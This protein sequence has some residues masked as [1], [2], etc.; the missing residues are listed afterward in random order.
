[1]T[2][3]RIFEFPILI[4]HRECLGLFIISR[5]DPSFSV[6]SEISRQYRCFNATGTQLTVRLLP[7][8]DDVENTDPMSHFV[9]S[10]NDLIDYALR[11]FADSDMVGLSITNE[12]NVQDK[13]IGLSFRRKDQLTA[14]VIWNV[15]QKVTNSRFNALDKLVVNVHAVKMPVGFG[16]D[17]IKIRGRPLEIMAH[18][19]K[20]IVQVKAETNC[21]AHALL[22]A[23]ARV[24][25]DPNYNSYLKGRKIL[26]EVQYLVK[27]P[28][29]NLDNGGG[30]P[31]LIK[32]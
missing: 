25:N 22:I 30:I 20:S 16:G 26:P 18:L 23:K 21:L 4:E 29:I 1:M 8:P 27:E 24:D 10:M 12:E 6:D 28:G 32:F 31:E 2:F 11:D 17:C 9:A 14:D 5:M 7:P 15:F 3:P 13:A 19:K